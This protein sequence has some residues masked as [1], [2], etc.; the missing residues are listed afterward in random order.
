MAQVQ[1]TLK[2]VEILF[3]SR[4]NWGPDPGTGE[5]IQVNSTRMGNQLGTGHRFLEDIKIL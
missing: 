3:P 1:N 5:M 4:H 2:I